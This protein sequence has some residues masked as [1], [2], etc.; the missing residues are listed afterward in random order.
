[1][2]V[3][4]LWQNYDSNANGEL[5]KSES[6]KLY[7]EASGMDPSVVGSANFSV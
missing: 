4:N 7:I 5:D 2:M 1:M 3:D 6:K